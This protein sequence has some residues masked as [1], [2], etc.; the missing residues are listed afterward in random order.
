MARAQGSRAVQ[1]L[2]VPQV[3]PERHAP[4]VKRLADDMQVPEEEA[5]VYFTEMLRFL[6]LA[7]TADGP[8]TPSKLIDEAWH[9]F[10]LFSREYTRYC[11]ERFNQ[12][13][14]HQPDDGEA[15]GGA[16]IGYERTRVLAEEAFGELDDR[17]W[18]AAVDATCQS[19][20]NCTSQCTSGA[21]CKAAS[22]CTSD[23]TSEGKAG[24]QEGASS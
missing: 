7:H 14:H 5:R 9:T 12:Y 10:M 22:N 13:I 17:A 11:Q 18:P 4:I 15:G 23:C 1:A 2:G 8:V 20:N 3:N 16:D 6:D 24:S 19:A 21:N